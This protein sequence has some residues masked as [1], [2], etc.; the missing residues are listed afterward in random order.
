MFLGRLWEQTATS[1][2]TEE[3]GGHTGFWEPGKMFRTLLCACVCGNWGVCVYACSLV[4][5]HVEPRHLI[6]PVLL[7]ALRI[8]FLEAEFLTEGALLVHLD[9]PASNP[10]ACF[11]RSLPV[12]GYRCAIMWV[13]GF[14]TLQVLYLLSHLRSSKVL[15]F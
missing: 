10:W 1:R 12:Q 2:T 9:Q 8:T 3:K 7:Y 11:Y 5:V 15:G 14:Q 4:Q 6:V 13:L